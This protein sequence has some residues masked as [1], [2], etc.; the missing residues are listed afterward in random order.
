MLA[1]AVPLLLKTAPGLDVSWTAPTG[2]PAQN[3]VSRDI[4]NLAGQPLP[5]LTEGRVVGRVEATPTG[6]RL[7]LDLLSSGKHEHRSIEAEDC[8]TLARAAALM[9]AVAVDPVATSTTIA[10]SAQ[11]NPGPATRSGVTASSAQPDSDRKSKPKPEPEPAPELTVEKAPPPGQQDGRPQLPSLSLGLGLSGGGALG[12]T[13]GR[14]GGLEAELAWVR[15]RL[16][17]TAAG[18]HWFSQ[19]TAVESGASLAAAV[20]GATVRGCHAASAAAMEFPVCMLVELSALHGSGIGPRVSARRGADLY[21]GVG[22]SVG[23]NWVIRPRFALR[24][25]IDV[26]VAVRRPGFHLNR[27][28]EQDEAFRMYR[29]GVRLVLGP[30]LRL[31]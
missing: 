21:V 17:L 28:L 4:Q 5:R 8:Q 18:H 6:Y 23:A 1:L 26:L 31:P 15:P 7:E 25:R 12:L 29:I 10:W 3:A 22:A 27:G 9:V 2:C 24:A 13:P 19:A 30:Q 20:S 16:R 14:T 11:P